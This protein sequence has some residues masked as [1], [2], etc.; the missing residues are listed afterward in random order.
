MGETFTDALINRGS[1]EETPRR[2]FEW[3]CKNHFNVFNIP[4][5]LIVRVTE[6]FNPYK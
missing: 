4:S 6:D 2:F 5:E 1:T 3:L